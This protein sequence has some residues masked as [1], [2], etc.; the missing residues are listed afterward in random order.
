MNTKFTIEE[1]SRVTGQPVS[2]NLNSLYD[3]LKYKG[4][5]VGL[6]QPQRLVAYLAQLA[7]ESGSFRHDREVWGPTAAQKR[8]DTRT[9]L[10]NTAAQDG[11]GFKNRGRT[12]IQITGGYNIASFYNW[13][14]TERLEPPNFIDDPDLMNTDPWEGLGPLWYWDT[15]NLN[16]WADAGDFANVTRKINGGTNGYADRCTWYTRIALVFLGYDADAV[17]EFQAEQKLKVDGIAGVKTRAALHTWLCQLPPVDF[18]FVVPKQETPLSVPIS[19]SGPL[20]ILT[21]PLSKWDIFLSWISR[22]F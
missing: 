21:E 5:I 9:D 7:H 10:G 2:A 15:R 19:E 13:C 14:V 8:Y 11:D 12:A 4:A 17:R 22:Y 18:N 16:T 6:R 1:L 20:L 3:G